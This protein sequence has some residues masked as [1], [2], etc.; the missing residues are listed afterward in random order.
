MKKFLKT[1]F[2]IC[3]S[4]VG[5]FAFAVI[6]FK[7]GEPVNALWL[8]VAS[9]CVFAVSYR[10]YSKWLFTKVFVLDLKRSTPA[11][12]K[13]DGKDYVKTNSWIVFGHHFAAI[14]GPGPLVGPVLAAQFGYLPGALWILVGAALGGAV[15]D[16]MILFCS[17]RRNG[18]S[19]GRMV[20][21]EI[22]TFAGTVALV[23]ILSILVILIAVLALG[24]PMGRIHHCNDHPDSA[25]DGRSIAVCMSQEHRDCLG[26]RSH[27]PSSFGLSRTVSDQ[28]PRD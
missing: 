20:K 27:R 10:F 18:K 11:C 6:A 2:W 3:F 14:A 23:G 16:S 17:M 5:A 22:N 9:L 4:L 19:L 12:V 24:K 7:R 13:E 15:H 26:V 1:L 28:F 21:E 8:V 25:P